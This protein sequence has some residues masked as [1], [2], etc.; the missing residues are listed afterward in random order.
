MKIKL[1]TSLIWHGVEYH[2]GDVVDMPDDVAR[3]YISTRQA[4]AM[5]VECAAVRTQPIKGTQDDRLQTTG[6]KPRTNY[7]YR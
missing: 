2:H 5:P 7:R 1:D 3:R 6:T 4:E